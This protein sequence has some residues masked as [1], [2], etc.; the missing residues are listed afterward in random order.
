MAS[1]CAQG[2][3]T[4][5][6]AGLAAVIALS[7]LPPC[8][9][10]AFGYPRLAIRSVT[11]PGNSPLIHKVR[12][13][14]PAS[15]VMI[16]GGRE[17]AAGGAGGSGMAAMLA[18]TSRSLLA[19]FWDEALILAEDKVIEFLEIG[20]IVGFLMEEM[21]G[22]PF[23]SSLPSVTIMHFPPSPTQPHGQERHILHACALGLLNVP[24]SS[25]LA[26]R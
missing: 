16:Q 6:L 3:T 7:S 1:S 22:D 9:S 17:A 20:G 12:P 13:A 8:E 14:S 5:M 21:V 10:L 11:R 23:L 25:A 4:M 19:N 26:S 24:T 18:S 15:V 2:S